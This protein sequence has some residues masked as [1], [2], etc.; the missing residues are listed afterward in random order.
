MPPGCVTALY[1]KQRDAEASL[2]LT[3]EPGWC[4]WPAWSPDGQILAYV[5]GGSDGIA[6]CT[7]AALGG[8]VRRLFRSGDLI[9]GVDWSRDGKWLVFSARDEASGS[10]KLMKLDRESL[11]A[12]VLRVSDQTAGED[13]QP[14]V[15]PAGGDLA[16]IPA[17]CPAWPGCPTAGTWCTGRP[18]RRRGCGWFRPPAGIRGP[19]I[20]AP[21]TP[22]PPRWRAAAG[23][24]PSPRCG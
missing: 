16:W 15:D 9:E 23:T 17:P 7:V 19:W 12:A 10:H 24:S 5:Q 13:L 11:E 1:I 14:R 18:G 20:R 4:A 6:L 22:S 2:R 8:A 3:G 21:S